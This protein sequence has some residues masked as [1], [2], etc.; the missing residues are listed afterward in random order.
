MLELCKYAPSDADKIASWI[1]DKNMARMW[2]RDSF[3]NFPITADDLNSYYSSC[4]SKLDFEILSFRCDG[5]LCGHLGITFDK[6]SNSARLG[7]IVVDPSKRGN[8]YGKQIVSLALEHIFNVQKCSEATLLVYDK[9]LPAYKCYINLG[10]RETSSENDIHYDFFGESWRFIQL[11]IT[12]EDFKIEN[13]SNN[14]N[15]AAK[16]D[17][18]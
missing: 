10:F 15:Y 14:K 17:S 12:A 7:F 8:G 11:K 1:K 2:G 4:K 3:S 16:L 9:N 18:Q 13:T 6:A 5:L